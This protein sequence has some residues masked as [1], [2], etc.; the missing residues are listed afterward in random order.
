MLEQG[1]ECDDGNQEPFDGCEPDRTIRLTRFF[2]RSSRRWPRA[3]AA[4]RRVMAVA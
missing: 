1:E 2:A 3:A 4:W